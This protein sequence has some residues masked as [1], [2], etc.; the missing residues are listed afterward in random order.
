MT[1]TLTGACHC[2]AIHVTLETPSQPAQ[3]P[4]RACVCSFC[5]KHGVRSTSD[6]QG[7]LTITVDDPAALHRYRFATRT[8][9]TLICANCGIYVGAIIEIDGT[10]Y[11]IVNVNVLDEQAPFER[12]PEPHDY[13]HE[14]AAERIARRRVKWSR[15]SL[16]AASAGSTGGLAAGKKVGRVRYQSIFMS[17]RIYDHRR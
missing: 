16:S 17:G 14:T 9:E 12:Q 4:L 5:R 7:A 8:A 2:G 15:P 3:L 10:L 1:H 13:T 6:P 11:G